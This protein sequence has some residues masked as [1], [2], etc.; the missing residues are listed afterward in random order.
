MH[1]YVCAYA[2]IYTHIHRGNPPCTA[3]PTNP[4]NHQNTT[5]TPHAARSWTD[6]GPTRE[7]HRLSFEMHA[8]LAK[9]L[10]LESYRPIPTLGVQVCDA[11]VT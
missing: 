6:S 2:Y 7:L 8:Q 3:T 1:I 9:D 5:S 10:A 11:C 4:T